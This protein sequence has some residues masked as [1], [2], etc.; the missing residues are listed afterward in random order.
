VNIAKP[1]SFS[2]T[3]ASSS[4][5]ASNAATFHRAATSPSTK[6]GGRYSSEQ[7]NRDLEPA[8]RAWRRYCRATDRTAV[9]RFLREVYSLVLMWK[10]AKR[11]ETR[12]RRLLRTQTVA[13][14]GMVAEPFASVIFASA[15]GRLDHRA[16]SKWSRALRLA[17]RNK[18][19]P[20]KLTR[21]IRRRGGLSRCAIL[22]GKCRRESCRS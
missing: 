13:P 7:L 12:A 17:A 20:R 19:P 9:Y 8:Y 22:L 21:F 1:Q 16:Q 5:I 14:K 4:R 15:G 3:R 11:S 18:V 6:P 2:S 10:L